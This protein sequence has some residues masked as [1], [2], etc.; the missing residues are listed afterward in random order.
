MEIQKDFQVLLCIWSQVLKNRLWRLLILWNVNLSPD[1]CSRLPSDTQ[2]HHYSPLDGLIDW[3]SC[4]N[5]CVIS[6][7]TQQPPLGKKIY[8]KEGKKCQDNS[9]SLPGRLH[10]H[11]LLE[12]QV[13]ATIM[14]ENPEDLLQGI[15]ETYLKLVINLPHRLP[16]PSQGFI[17]FLSS[18]FKATQE[19]NLCLHRPAPGTCSATFRASCARSKDLSC[20]DG[21]LWCTVMDMHTVESTNAEIMVLSDIYKSLIFASLCKSTMFQLAN[22]SWEC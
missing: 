17:L 7:G 6:S 20:G 9:W 22:W 16:L 8:V 13:R 15:C 14:L 1:F 4:L 21:W 12:K 18:L 2:P 11:A 10:S 19:V 5:S 3:W